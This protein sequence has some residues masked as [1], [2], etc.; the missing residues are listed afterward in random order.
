MQRR[1]AVRQLIVALIALVM[2]GGACTVDVD[3][4]V[5]SAPP[6]ASGSTQSGASAGNP[7]PAE[8]ADATEP[9]SSEASSAQ[10]DSSTDAESPTSAP[11][12]QPQG[13]DALAGSVG[14][15]DTIYPDLGN[16]GYDVGTYDLVIDWDDDNRTIAATAEIGLLAT[17][18]LS[19]FN[20]ELI[21][22]EITGVTVNDQPA[23]WSRAEDELTI[24]PAQTIADQETAKVE[25]AYDGKP[26]QIPS[27]LGIA[28]GWIDLGDG[29]IVA[30]EPRGASGW[31]PVN[32]HP[33]DKAIYTLTVTADDDLNVAS[34]G[35]LKSSTPVDGRTTWNFVNEHP[36]AS[37]LV[38]LAIGDY[39]RHEGRPSESGV[40]VR[41]YFHTDT[42][43]KAVA[44][45]ERTGEM[46]DAFEAMFGPYPF[47]SYGTVVANAPFGFALETQT[48]SV[49]GND[50][51]IGN[52]LIGHEDI[53]AHELAHQWFGNHVSLGQWTDIWLN[54][55]FASYSEFLWKEASRPDYDIDREIQLEHGLF[56]DFLSMPPGAAPADDLF[57]AS[58][59]LRGGFTLHALRTTIG[60]DVFF[61][62][63]NTWLVEYGGSHATTD[64]FISLAEDVSGQDLGDFFNAWLYE[65]GMP[66]LPE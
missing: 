14:L 12:A 56:R 39:E 5:D 31:F 43:E 1:R 30:G 2:L 59:Y 51:L 22:F 35:T 16:G 6:T 21:G 61:R 4:A 49:F 24:V 8:S 20:L 45:M 57:N 19:R 7:E 54:E 52:E 36:M 58:V 53:V 44:T 66:P 50:L 60:D 64:N 38:T 32:E 17:Q 13:G 29:I 47:E 34:N 46:I 41:H 40:P 9:D 55:G 33:T 65:E 3:T 42:F 10:A 28:E 63:V 62:L 25:I 48:L 37:Y 15:G 27:A 11:D 23:T 26:S 18:D